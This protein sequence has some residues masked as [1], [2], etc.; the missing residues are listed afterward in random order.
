MAGQEDKP[1][2]Q[3]VLVAEAVN[4]L[5]ETTAGITF[6]TWLKNRCFF[7]SSTI[8][9]NPESHE[10]NIYGTLFNEASRRVYLD[11]RRNIRPELRKRI[12][13]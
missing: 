1:K 3:S 12:E 10:I 9:G 5:A 11:V 13:Q 6:L 7:E 4:E 8:A 2:S